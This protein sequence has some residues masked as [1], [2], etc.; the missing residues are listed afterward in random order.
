MWGGDKQ[1]KKQRCI[2]CLWEVQVNG[3]CVGGQDADGKG[4]ACLPDMTHMDVM[5]MPR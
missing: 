3:R 4:P 5:V 1:T 2:M